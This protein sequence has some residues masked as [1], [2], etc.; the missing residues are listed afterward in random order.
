MAK[1]WPFFDDFLGKVEMVCAKADLEVARLYVEE[2]GGDVKLFEELASEFERTVKSIETIRKRPL[3]SNQVSL[4]TALDLRD[5]YLDP[6][7]LLDI[8]L[9]KRKRALS[10]DASE[11]ELLNKALGTALN[12][13]AQGL[14]NTG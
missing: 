5:P 4:R 7:N 1:H 10:V 14:R 8:S 2:L 13:V 9:L 6:L 11:T 12:G 3:L